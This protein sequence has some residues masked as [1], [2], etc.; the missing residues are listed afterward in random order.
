[1]P[2]ISNQKKDKIVE[3]ILHLLFSVFPKPLFTSDI[4]KELARDEEFIKQILLDL[5][6]REL[7]L[8][9]DKNPLGH[10]YIRRIR[11]RISNKVY[12]AY[13]TQQ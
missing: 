3:Q 8:K 4:A 7:T 12:E 1:M 6:K 10:N 5:N 11:W 13:K 2:K 9:L